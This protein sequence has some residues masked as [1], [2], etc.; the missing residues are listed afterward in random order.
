MAEQG[1]QASD[2]G[3]PVLLVS[4]VGYA[5]G[6]VPHGL[7]LIKGYLARTTE[8]P[9]ETLSLC[10][11]F[12]D[13]V[14]QAHPALAPYD[15]QM[16]EWG[17]S[18]HELY[19]AARYFGHAEP[20]AL[21]RAAATDFLQ[22]GDI[23]RATP[24]DEPREARP[25]MVEF[26]TARIFELC[27]LIDEHARGELARELARRPILIGF[28]VMAQQLYGSAVLARACRQ[29]CPEAVIVFGG[30]AIT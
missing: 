21:L 1:Q 8:L 15:R 26:H 16:G 29:A 11:R 7:G 18:F 25:A 10:V 22:G 14:R 3:G 19:F 28:S 4:T 23:F 6:W 2:P 27:R 20:E 24:W 12:S 30:P 5:H 9:I 13:H 17:S